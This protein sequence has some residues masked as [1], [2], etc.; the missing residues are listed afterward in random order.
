M[1]TIRSKNIAIFS[2]DLDSGADYGDGRDPGCDTYGEIQWSP[3]SSAIVDGWAIV[4]PYDTDHDLD[5]GIDYAA[6]L[7]DYAADGICAELDRV[8]D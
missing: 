6:D 1:Q 5:L 4:D 7:S 3:D 8:T 2:G